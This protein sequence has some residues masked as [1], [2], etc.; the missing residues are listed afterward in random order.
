VNASHGRTATLAAMVTAAGIVQLPTA[1]IVVAIPTIH[2]DLDAS[3]AE[4]TWTVTAF[5]IP[6]AAFLIAAGRI[7]DIFGRKRMLFT[8]AGL[9]AAGSA[10]A[11]AAPDAQV[12]I[13]GVAVSGV[14]G[15]LLMPSSMSLLTNVFTGARRGFAIGMWGAATELVSGIGVLVGGVLTGALSW[16]WIF[17]VNIAFALL[18]VVLAWRNTPESRDPNAPRRVDVPGVILTASGLTMITLA[19]IQGATWG[20]GSPAIILL[21]IGG[22]AAFAFF[23]VVERRTENPLIDFDFFKRR[24][25][26]GA[27]TTIFVIDFSFGALLFFLPAYFQEVLG[28]TPTETGALLLPLTGTMVVASPL[29]GRFASRT[30]PRPPIVIGLTMMFAAI[31]WISTLDL[32]TTYA[33]LWAPTAIMGF[34]IGLALTPMNLA[35]MNAVSRHHAGAASG[36]LVTLSG[37]GATLGVAV[38]GAIF[39][40]LQEERTVEL[41]GDAGVTVS[42]AQAQELEGVLA[43]TAGAQHELDKL[44]GADVSQVEHA[45][46]EA[47]VSA[48]GTSLR[49][50][51]ALVA[52]GILLAVVLLRRSEPA[53]AAPVAELTPSV[54]PRPA[55]LEAADEAAVA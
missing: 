45:V 17:V 50:S 18:I 28:Y 47:F 38:T 44:A 26:T 20:W 32:S 15:A 3:L 52:L 33:D 14:G 21:L 30:G 36:I 5:Y 7:A 42:D 16:R 41:V 43:G 51:A 10:L 54:T 29:G 55:P 46:R 39:S 13:A 22:L 1:A 2:A 4:L 19:L 40:Q 6:F 53:D 37:L 9:F 27:T 31:S 8:G 34:G 24:N 12:L 25:F 23:A 11:A 49:I 35:A 48:L